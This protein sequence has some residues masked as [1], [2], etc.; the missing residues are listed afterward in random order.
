MSIS[1]PE[2]DKYT[3]TIGSPVK[4]SLSIPV[5]IKTASSVPF[6]SK[7]PISNCLIAWLSFPKE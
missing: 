2:V 3:A 5:D 6:P 1:A 7:S 4:G